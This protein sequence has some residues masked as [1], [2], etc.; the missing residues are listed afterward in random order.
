VLNNYHNEWLDKVKLNYNALFKDMDTR[1]LLALSEL[2]RQQ[3]LLADRYGMADPRFAE[4]LRDI[5]ST[6]SNRTFANVMP[7]VVEVLDTM[8]KKHYTEKETVC[9]SFG[10]AV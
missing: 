3:R 2:L 9:Q 8:T 7:L 4:A 1:Q 5:G 6:I 10:S